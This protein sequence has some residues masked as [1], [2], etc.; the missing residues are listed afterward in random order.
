MKKIKEVDIIAQ[1]KRTLYE[2]SHAKVKSKLEV[3]FDSFIYCDLNIPIGNKYGRMNIQRLA[4]GEPLEIKVCQKCLFF[5]RMGDPV[6]P[7]D[8]GWVGKRAP[9][10]NPEINGTIGTNFPKTGQS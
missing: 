1:P 10:Y 6:K 9:G 3:P 8:R 4:R 5:N 7:E 2:C